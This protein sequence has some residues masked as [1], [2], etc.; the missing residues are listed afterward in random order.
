[1][2]QF[3]QKIGLFLFPA[4]IFSGLTG[5]GTK[6]NTQTNET[7]QTNSQTE[8]KGENKSSESSKYPP[9]PTA[10]S[11]AELELLD[12]SKITIEDRKGKVLLFNLWGIWCGPCRAEMPELI[13]MQEKFKDKGL[14]I[15]GL[16]VGDED[17]NPE[18]VDN[19]KKFSEKMGLNYELVRVSNEATEQMMKA[20][21]FSGVPQSYLI[22]REGHL[23]GVF[24]GGGPKVLGQ[25]K[26]NVEKVVNE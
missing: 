14:H 26:E 8:N 10:M 18:N 7:A 4:I 3:L 19:I 5:C 25:L 23:R 20:S 22:D 6:T 24:V 16:N 13:A 1:M 17:G 12:G 2:K 9:A 21:K 11:K 15:I